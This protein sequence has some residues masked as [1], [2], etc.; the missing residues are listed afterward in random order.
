MKHLKRNLIWKIILKITETDFFL[1][2][3][4]NDLDLTGFIEK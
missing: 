2:K 3:T 1:F 4:L